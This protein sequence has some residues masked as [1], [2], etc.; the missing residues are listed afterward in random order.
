MI[1][2]A[3]L[4]NSRHADGSLL[5]HSGRDKKQDAS[6]TLYYLKEHQFPQYLSANNSPMYIAIRYSTQKMRINC[7]TTACNMTVHLCSVMLQQ[8]SMMCLLP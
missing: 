7:H 1:M 6:A 3:Y 8:M 4:S 2:A 5:I